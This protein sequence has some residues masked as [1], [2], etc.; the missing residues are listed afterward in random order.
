MINEQEN[1]KKNFEELTVMIK[2]GFDDV[3]ERLNRIE[4]DVGGLKDDVGGLKADVE[5]LKNG[6]ERIE[7]RL[8]NVVYRSE[9]EKLKEKVDFLMGKI[10]TA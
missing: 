6:Q 2:D 4:K 10:E 7:M 5:K 8:M 9:F 1:Y 3:G